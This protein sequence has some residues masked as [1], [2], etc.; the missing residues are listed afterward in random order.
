ML[1][2][3]IPS[4][5]SMFLKVIRLTTNAYFHI[6]AKYITNKTSPY[7]LKLLTDNIRNFCL[8][9]ICAEDVS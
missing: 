6:S 8:C 1:L 9:K 3:N 7:I 5:T 4:I 2:G